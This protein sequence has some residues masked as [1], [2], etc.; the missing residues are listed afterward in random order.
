MQQLADRQ[1]LDMDLLL[2]VGGIGVEPRS[3]ALTSLALV[4]AVAGVAKLRL[5]RSFE[6]AIFSWGIPVR[7]VRGLALLL[8]LAEL[9]LAA[10][11]LA[12]AVRDTSWSLWAAALVLATFLGGQLFL[13]LKMS[14]KVGAATCGCFGR[15]GPVG[16]SSLSRTAVLLGLAVVGVVIP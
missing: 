16:V 5:R 12:D 13:L 11:L 7:L 9:V 2:L 15:P 6:E 8:P 4:F 3:L 1:R 10:A 14:R